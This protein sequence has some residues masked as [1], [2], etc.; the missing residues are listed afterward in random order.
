[1]DYPPLQSQNNR[2]M[3]PGR[4]PPAGKPTVPGAPVDPA[5]IS[6]QMAGTGAESRETQP[7]IKQAENESAVPIAKV[8]PTPESS[9]STTKPASSNKDPANNE[10]RTT[11]PAKQSKVGESAMVNVEHN[12][13]DSFRQFASSEKM[14][15]H[16]QRRQRVS[17]DK[18]IKLNDLMKFSQN[19]KL[20]TPVPKDLVPILAKDKSKQEEIIEKAQR[21]VQS[22]T[23]LPQA[24]ATTMPETKSTRPVVEA[25]HEASRPAIP[26][27]GPQAAQS[28]RDRQQLHNGP[29]ASSKAG[30][31]LLGHR[32]ADTHR[33]HK[34]GLQSVTIPQPLPI[35]SISR[36]RANANPSQVPQSQSSST[37][38]TPTSAVSAKFN[39]GAKEFRPN[40]AANSFRPNGEP[41]ATSSP[42]R[43]TPHAKPP[44][45]PLSPSD[46]F[47]TKKPPPRAERQTISDNFNPLKRL[48]VR[49]QEE[50]KEHK[51]NGGIRHAYTTPPTW[52]NPQA[53]ED[54]KS[55]KQMFEEVIPLPSR[56]SPQ[57]GS[58]SHPPLPH[59]HQLPLH[60]QHNSHGLPHLPNP[61]QM[62]FPT[63]PQPLQY[64]LGPH[65]DEHRMHLSTSS[66]SVYPSPRMHNPTMAYPSPMPQTA[67]LAYGQAIPQY[68]MAPS[69]PQASHYGRQFPGGPQMIPAQGPHFVA[70]MMA[71]QSSQGGFVAPPHSV[72]LP[73]H[74]QVQMFPPG[75]PSSYSAQSQ[76][77]SGYPSPGRGAP[78]MMHQGSHQGQHSQTY[79][80]PGPYG[81]PIYAQQPPPHSKF[82]G[83]IYQVTL[84]IASD[85][86]EGLW[87]PAAA[88]Q[89]ES[90]AA[91]SLSSP[92]KPCSK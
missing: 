11:A 84:I 6:L 32:L 13:L 75:Q 59:Q 70:P 77:T 86:C 73:I 82:I 19:F 49:A 25:K 53:N 10:S 65:Y 69:G 56:A 36:S 83:S 20:M 9:K 81:Q 15:L 3:P 61:Q 28:A 88:L 45:R 64:T 40:P 31:G 67:Q 22:S 5:I 76:P 1:M 91:V 74:P 34:V 7:A 41:S 42:N 2:Y 54:F 71:Q 85:A 63:Q 8:E 33:Q 18:A 78:M 62:P 89:P 44:I 23:T 48:K 24:L 51:E 92:T 90:T 55:Y 17:Q 50:G 52:N 58:P 46:F 79:M 12:L 47:G 29:F 30:Q 72:G 21:N 27:Q 16:D 66:S 26:P 87:F 38:R 37:V 14:K 80:N 68:V 39:G 35:H 57:H 43:S 4:R 60:L